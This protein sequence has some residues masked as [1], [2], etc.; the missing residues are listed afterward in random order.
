MKRNELMNDILEDVVIEMEMELEEC[1]DTE[2]MH[3]TIWIYPD[4]TVHSLTASTI[5]GRTTWEDNY[6]K[7]S[8]AQEEAVIAFMAEGFQVVGE[9]PVTW[10]GGVRR[11]GVRYV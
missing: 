3:E 7:S 8:I 11:S 10:A 5:E 6:W 1:G 4:G 2:T 9:K